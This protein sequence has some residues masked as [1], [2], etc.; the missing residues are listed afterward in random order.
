MCLAFLHA[1]LELLLLG[2][3]RP[4][5]FKLFFLFWL[6]GEWPIRTELTIRHFCL[7]FV[8]TI[9]EPVFRVDVKQRAHDPDEPLERFSTECHKT[10][11]KVITLANHK[12]HK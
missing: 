3:T 9:D 5:P 11:T 4:R 2:P 10:K 12:K 7:Q 6:N 8:Q 1:I